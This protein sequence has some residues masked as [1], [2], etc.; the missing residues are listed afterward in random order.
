MYMNNTLIPPSPYTHYSVPRP[1]V[2]NLSG[3]LPE[4]PLVL[5]LKIRRYR[6]S[7]IKVSAYFTNAFRPSMVILPQ[8]ISR[9]SDATYRV[10]RLRAHDSG[11]T[12]P[13][14]FSVHGLLI[15]SRITLWDSKYL[16]R[17]QLVKQNVT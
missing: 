13:Y 1:S 12:A 6:L 16:H 7:R 8:R 9:N 14:I 17:L 5:F 10:P 4:C 11:L 15:R 2:P 3:S